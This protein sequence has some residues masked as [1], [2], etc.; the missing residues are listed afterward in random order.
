MNNILVLGYS[1]VA[2]FDL[3]ANKKFIRPNE[4]FIL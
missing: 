4:I 2:I 1:E 3:K